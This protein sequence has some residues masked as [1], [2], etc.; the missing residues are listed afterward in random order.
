MDKQHEDNIRNLETI[1]QILSE[2]RQKENHSKAAADIGMPQD[3]ILKI[4]K[5]SDKKIS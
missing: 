5:S 2:K 1:R 4:L 3:A